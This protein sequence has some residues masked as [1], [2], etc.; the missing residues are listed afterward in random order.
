MSTATLN[1]LA[2]LH[3]IQSSYVD[4]IGRRQT[5][6]PESI[7]RG[8]QLLGAPVRELD[9]VPAAFRQRRQE[10]WGRPMEPVCVIWEGNPP[11]VELRIGAADDDAAF[12]AR[13]ML[14]DGE[15]REYSGRLAD[16]PQR[17][18]AEVEGTS[19]LVKRLCLDESLPWGYHRLSL[20]YG[21]RTAETMVM[22]APK[23]SYQVEP[24]G[25]H[26]LWGV[27]LPLYALHRESS[28][29]AGD[30]SDLEALMQWVAGQGGSLVAT[31]PL[32][33]SQTDLNGDP[34]PYSP[35]SRLFWNEFYLDLARVPEFAHCPAAQALMEAADIQAHWEDLRREPL[36]DYR[37]QA[38]AK[39]RILTVLAESFFASEGPRREALDRYCREHPLAEDY[40][41]YRAVGERQNAPWPA[42]PERLQRGEITPGD[43][44]QQVYH[45]HLY[46][47]WQIEQQ[48]GEMT[49]HARRS[50]LIWY[51]DF[52]LGVSGDGFDVWRQPEIFV[53]EA[54]G[55]APPDS[56]FTKGQNW[57]FPPMHPE[58]LR[59]QGYDYLIASLRR[60]LRYARLLRIDHVMSMHRLFWV[61]QGFD[62]IDGVYVRYPREEMFAVLVL[63]SHR[64]QAQVVGENL[65]TVPEAVNQAMMRHGVQDMYVLQYEQNES[66]AIPLRPVPSTAVSSLN[67]HD[68][69]Q[70]AAHWTGLDIDA[71]VELGLLGGE[72]A[73]RLRDER[74]V[75]RRRLVDW[76]CGVG[77][78]EENTLDPLEVLEACLAWLG[79]SQAPVVLVNLEDLWQETRPQNTPGTFLERPNWRRKA[80][81]SLEQFENLPDVVR[82]LRRVDQSRRRAAEEE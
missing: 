46:A 70:F 42:W 25:R 44:D 55:G 21:G 38:G 11:A 71:R 45:Y 34:S 72:E 69:P 8:L 13:L 56:F 28:W 23:E 35:T 18:T 4:V 10:L 65:G 31:L 66:G 6:S 59:Q 76:L 57:G 67:T 51:L 50:N 48:L 60:H 37:R 40:A 62:A 27:F 26:F 39:R 47:Q 75:L 82:I 16:L 12:S 2:R 80:R 54:A 77:L 81:Y 52:P 33:A 30:F 7:L 41:R 15:T 61:P 74:A 78:L 63:E 1:N 3:G 64:H 36:V 17:R 24:G 14:E 19:F 20:E 22:V 9:D 68:M 79:R 73:C 58:R 49:E 53:R 29:G 43:Y 32:L 5:A